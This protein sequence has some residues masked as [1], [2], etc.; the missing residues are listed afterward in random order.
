MGGGLTLEDEKQVST[1]TGFQLRFFSI[2][3]SFVI[4]SVLNAQSRC[5]VEVKLLLT[6]TEDHAA[7][8]AF[9][10]NKETTG[11]VYFFDT[12]TL[13]LLSQGVIVRLRRGIG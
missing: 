1:I 4:C 9:H 7:I 5:N 2:W 11:F 8:T 10:F 12:N 6:P 3:A 13:D